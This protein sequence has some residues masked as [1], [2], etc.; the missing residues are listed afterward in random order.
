MDK[1]KGSREYIENRDRNRYRLDTPVIS[2]TG[3]FGLLML[4]ALGILKMIVDIPYVVVNQDF[5]SWFDKSNDDQKELNLPTVCW[6]IG[7]RPL[8]L[9]VSE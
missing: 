6:K 8:K 9:G 2:K 1:L 4:N 7:G 3:F 5:L